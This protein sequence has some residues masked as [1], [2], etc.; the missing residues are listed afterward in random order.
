D[1]IAGYLIM[2]IGEI[3]DA[4]HP[5]SFTLDDGLIITS[6]ELNGSRIENV[7]V[8]VPDNKIKN[9]TTNMYKEKY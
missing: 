1:T 7:I 6:G 4:K 5:K 3:P 9:V 2:N 8:T